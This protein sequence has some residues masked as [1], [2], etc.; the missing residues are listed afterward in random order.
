MERNKFGGFMG[1]E[2]VLMLLI[3]L[4]FGLVSVIVHLMTIVEPY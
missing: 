2:E 1:K 4:T 3:A